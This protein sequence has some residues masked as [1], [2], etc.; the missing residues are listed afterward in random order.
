MATSTTQA[1]PWAP[2]NTVDVEALPVGEWWDAISAPTSVADRALEL[3]GDRSGA[4]IQDD[5][6]GKTYWLIGVDTAR[7]WCMRQV[8]VLT[9]LADEGTLLGVPPASWGPEH[10]THWR[11][12][13]GPDRYLT[14]SNHLARALRPAV[15]EVL[16]PAPDGRQ[17]CYRCQ[18]PTDE[19]VPVAIQH[20]G[21]FARTTVY[22]C[23]THAR[24]YPNDTVA[25]A[26]AMRRALKFGRSR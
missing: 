7:S 6:Y 25:Q 2:P 21:S 11:I 8:R 13:L 26:A 5:T 10:R 15:D 16:G 23:P 18:L 17:L 22:A 24:D 9:T 4:V 3:L 1:F 12:P 19:P 20:S 14:D